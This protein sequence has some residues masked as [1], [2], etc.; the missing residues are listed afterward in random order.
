V[1]NRRAKPIRNACCL[2]S[3]RSSRKPAGRCVRSMESPLVQ[4][5]ARSRGCASPVVSRRGF[6]WRPNCRWRR[7]LR[8]RRW[9]RRAGGCIPRPMSSHASMPGCARCMCRRM[10]GRRADGRNVWCP[11]SCRLTPLRY[12]PKTAPHG[13]AREAGSRLILH[14]RGD[15]VSR[16]RI[17]TPC[18][19]RV[20]SANL[21]NRVALSTAERAAGARL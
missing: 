18:R 7:Y 20:R 6:R 21:R 12:L 14:W 1:A 13:S 15:W 16:A 9:R 4:D 5:L 11:R 3:M 10:R 17:L 8:L 2:L 19:T